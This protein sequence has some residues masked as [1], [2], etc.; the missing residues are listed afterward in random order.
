MAKNKKLRG[1]CAADLLLIFFAYAKSRFSHGSYQIVTVAIILS[2]QRSRKM[3]VGPQIG[4]VI[5]TFVV[6]LEN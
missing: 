6:N 2:K 1:N 5:C 3:Q 4:R